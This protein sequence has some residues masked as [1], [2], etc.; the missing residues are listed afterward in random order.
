[1]LTFARCEE[2]NLNFMSKTQRQDGLTALKKSTN[3]K[4][5]GLKRQI[6]AMIEQISQMTALIIEV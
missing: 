3:I 4:M 5:K 6:E 1:M 2:K